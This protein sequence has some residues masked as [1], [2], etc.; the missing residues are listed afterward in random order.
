MSY[1]ERVIYW[2]IKRAIL[3]GLKTLSE[4]RFVFFLL[5]TLS[6]IIGTTFLTVLNLTT[7]PEFQL[8]LS[9]EL[10]AALVFLVV[11]GLSLIFKRLAVNRRRAVFLQG[12]F[13]SDSRIT[14]MVLKPIYGIDLVIKL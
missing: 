8:L 1:I 5:L 6:T 12:L 14:F 2:Y 7:L 10:V 11:G 4:K 9:I 3:G 13:M